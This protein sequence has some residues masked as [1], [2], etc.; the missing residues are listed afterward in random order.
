M[1]EAFKKLLIVGTISMYQQ[2]IL[3]GMLDED[4]KIVQQEKISPTFTGNTYDFAVQDEL[5][6]V[7][8]DHSWY[9]KFERKGR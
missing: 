2:K 6:P 1:S 8:K 7:E 5:V 9:R 4:F 3:E